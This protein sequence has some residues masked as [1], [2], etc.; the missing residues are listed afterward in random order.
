MQGEGCDSRAEKEAMGRKISWRRLSPSLG[1]SCCL[2]STVFTPSSGLTHPTKAVNVHNL[3]PSQQLSEGPGKDWQGS[4]VSDWIQLPC[5][6]ES[7]PDLNLSFLPPDSVR[8][9]SRFLLHEDMLWGRRNICLDTWRK[10]CLFIYFSGK[11]VTGLTGG[12]Q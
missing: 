7:V 12:L 2:C 11:A 9:G 10:D 1:R 3:L 5:K 8:W 6:S 4:R